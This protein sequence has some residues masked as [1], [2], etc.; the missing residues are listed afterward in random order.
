MPAGEL[1]STINFNS[2]KYSVNRTKSPGLLALGNN[3]FEKNLSNSGFTI[4]K[5]NLNLQRI[6]NNGGTSPRKRVNNDIFHKFNPKQSSSPEIEKFYPDNKHVMLPMKSVRVLQS[7]D[8][9]RGGFGNS[10]LMCSGNTA[11]ESDHHQSAVF[12]NSLHRA[13]GS[14]P[15]YLTQRNAELQQKQKTQEDMKTSSIK[16]HFFQENEISKLKN[17]F[18][19]KAMETEPT[20]HFFKKDSKSFQENSTYNKLKKS[21]KKA[22]QIEDAANKIEINRPD[23]EGGPSIMLNG[24]D[25][26]NVM[27]INT[28]L[29]Q[30]KGLQ[31][32]KRGSIRNM[33]GNE[34][35]IGG[36]DFVEYTNMVHQNSK[37]LL[38]TPQYKEFNPENIRFSA[39]NLSSKKSPPPN[40]GTPRY[41]EDS[42]GIS[43]F[44]DR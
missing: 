3:I 43:E 12:T 27:N 24:R 6:A 44:Q 28:K 4:S 18:Y 22:I 19:G 20:S 31:I 37:R 40:S 15:R 29:M 16:Q 17:K 36:Q 32:R 23:R 33:L 7:P 5:P 41:Q 2:R 14:S 1:A 10:V 30:S 9:F 26:Y 34:D 35:L 25:S 8:R 11:R 38:E 13:F 39:R 21:S 42:S